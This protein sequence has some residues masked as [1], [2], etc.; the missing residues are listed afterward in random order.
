VDNQQKVFLKVVSLLRLA[1]EEA[2]NEVLTEL[3]LVGYSRNPERS[4]EKLEQKLKEL[5]AVKINLENN[6]INIKAP[7]EIKALIVPDI[8]ERALLRIYPSSP[9]E[10]EALTI[11]SNLRR[12][13][14][15]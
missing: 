12:D 6:E 7:P 4:K 13:F 2:L 14:L 15:K 8:I 11:L 3:S 1:H 10:K 5:N 9:Q